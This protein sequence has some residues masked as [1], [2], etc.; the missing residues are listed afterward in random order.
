MSKTV[1]FS[2]KDEI[3][4]IPRREK[5]NLNLNQ[6][7][8]LLEWNL[9]TNFEYNNEI[10][11]SDDDYFLNPGIP[12]SNLCENLSRLLDDKVYF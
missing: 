8:N 12:H 11:L 2:D 6:K 4:E 10:I 7:I 9:I 5:K 3:F 1:R